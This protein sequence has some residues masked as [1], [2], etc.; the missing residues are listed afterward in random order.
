[1][2][3]SPDVRLRN[4]LANF[5]AFLGNA[6][7]IALIVYG[8]TQPWY[9]E[10][11]GDGYM[12][13]EGRDAGVYSVLILAVAMLCA[14]VMLLLDFQRSRWLLGATFTLAAVTA[15]FTAQGLT[16]DDYDPREGFWLVMFGAATAATG[17]VAALILANVRVA[18]SEPEQT[19]D[20]PSKDT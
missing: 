17:S 5:V 14:A 8:C 18:A 19:M 4:N 2:D 1:M 20:R 15:A 7:G 10:F 12:P 13:I 16:R 9:D 11:V 6:L 3:E